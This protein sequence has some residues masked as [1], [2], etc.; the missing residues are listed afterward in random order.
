MVWIRIRIRKCIIIS[1]RLRQ[2]WLRWWRWGHWSMTDLLSISI[3][4][5]CRRFRSRRLVSRWNMF[6]IGRHDRANI[7]IL[8]FRHFRKFII[9][10]AMFL[11]NSITFEQCNSE[12]NSSINTAWL[13]LPSWTNQLCKY[14]NWSCF[15]RF[16]IIETANLAAWDVS[17]S[18]VAFNS[19]KMVFSMISKMDEI[20]IFTIC[21]YF[22]AR[23]C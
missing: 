17:N 16:L 6:S 4:L 8:L 15:S 11:I 21:Q 5:I 10:V 13:T 22:R 23:N 19:L 1:F 20:S 7:R 2:W 14:L 9:I 18:T 3:H 12:N